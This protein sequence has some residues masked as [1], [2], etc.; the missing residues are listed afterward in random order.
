[1]QRETT[2]DLLKECRERLSEARNLLNSDRQACLEK[3]DTALER[4]LKYLCIKYGANSSTAIDEDGKQISFDNWEF[5]HC[6]RYLGGKNVMPRILGKALSQVRKVRNEAKH[7]GGDELDDVTVIKCF[8]IVEYAIRSLSDL[9]KPTSRKHVKISPFVLPPLR[10]K[11]ISINE[12]KKWEEKSWFVVKNQGSRLVIS[13][14][15]YSKWELFEIKL[16]YLFKLL[17][18]EDCIQDIE[19]FDYDEL[20]AQIDVCGGFEGIFLIINCV[21]K[22]ELSQETL[23]HKIKEIYSNRYK[24][25]KEINTLYQNKYY[26]QK[27]VICLEGIEISEKDRSEA[28]SADIAIITDDQVSNWFKYYKT[29]G[30]ALKYHI[31][32]G[33]TGTLVTILDKEKDPFFHYPAFK[34]KQGNK[35]FYNFLADPQS[36]TKIAYVYRLELG[37]PKGYQR[38]LRR[39]KL[40]NI[41]QFLTEEEAYFA[42]SIVMTFDTFSEYSTWSDFD[43]SPALRFDNVQVG[44]LNVPKIYC[45]AEVIDGQ[46]RLYGYLDASEAQKYEKILK[47]RRKTDRIPVVA[48]V[49]P[50]QNERAKL[51]TDINAN[52]TKV[53]IRQLWTLMA[54]AKPDSLMG[55]IA[56][57]VIKLN[58]TSTFRNRIHIPGI[59]Y[60]RK[61]MNI[62]NLGKGIMD[63]K[64]VDND[65]RYIW[66][67]FP[68]S[69]NERNY[70]NVDTSEPVKNIEQFYKPFSRNKKISDFVFTNNGFNV[71][72]RVFTS[73]LRFDYSRGSMTKTRTKAAITL[74]AL[75]SFLAKEK[76][77]IDK[78]LKHTSNEAGRADVARQIMS[79]IIKQGGPEL[80]E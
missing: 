26:K 19:N 66:N 25:S 2:S 76:Y 18:F 78:L 40:L 16:R 79:E 21:S 14:R 64:L 30:V 80:L 45:S 41:N 22:D 5:K 67:L 68:G 36:L 57:L 12:L 27:F 50:D 20:G 72:L 61:K 46:H 38:D 10:R 70:L 73:W 6:M 43:P 59:N 17:Q 58:N 74:K 35:I 53:E 51:F 48:V 31:V 9:K 75:K 63:R 11:T 32:K 13:R 62:A 1:M 54:R 47:R 65:P 23:R 7:S 28:E 71:L 37:D 49:D 55:Y 29:L 52:Q 33:L 77:Q 44:V 4:F 69:R 39:N 56:N 15:K 24:I 3:T 42:N 34:I 8:A 60:S